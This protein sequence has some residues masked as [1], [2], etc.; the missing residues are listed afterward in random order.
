MTG[1]DPAA[2][3]RRLR[4]GSDGASDRLAMTFLAA[5]LSAVQYSF[6]RLFERV[7]E[8]ALRLHRLGQPHGATVGILVQSQESQVL[9]Y[10]SAL[11]AGLVP[12]ILTPPNRKLDRE[13][14]E[15]TMAS[16]LDYCRFGVVVTDLA[17]IQTT[18]M[19]VEP[20]SMQV[21]QRSGW[22]SDAPPVDGAF[23]QF[24]SGTTGIKRGVLVSAAAATAQIEAYARAI[25]LADGDR[26]LG[27]LPLYHD[28]GFMTSLN[29]ALACGVHS[30]MMQPLDWVADP[31]LYL[32]AASAHRATLGWHPNFALSLIHI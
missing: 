30:L 15:R 25:G 3:F 19:I 6:A 18:S 24:S 29:M 27:W 13:Y 23:L 28:M 5:D 12:A 26:I 9:H 20:D 2:L 16:V 31:G 14:Y 8:M 4:S 32:R 21:R 17:G 11:S 7:D 10:L 22:Q 1:G